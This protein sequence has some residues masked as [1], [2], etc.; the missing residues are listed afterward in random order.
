MALISSGHI[1]EETILAV[2]QGK[3]FELPEYR[4]RRAIMRQDYRFFH[5]GSGFVANIFYAQSQWER[6]SLLLTPEI[7][8]Y[9]TSQRRVS[10]DNGQLGFV[11]LPRLNLEME[12][13]GFVR[14]D[15]AD[16]VS[17]LVK[18]GL[19]EADSSVVDAVRGGDCFKTTASGWAHMRLLSARLEYITS[20]LPT[21]P[22][23]DE[24][25]RANVFDA[26]QTEML[27]GFNSLNRQIIMGEQFLR[28]LR[29]LDQEQRRHP[30]Y[31]QLRPFGTT[32]VIEKV[33]SAIAHAK[34]VSVPLQPDLLDT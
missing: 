15:V 32:Y 27:T 30:G 26:M 2:A 21:T 5:D 16:S 23:D 11:A 4:I 3:V 29:F 7:L 33:A 8:F 12:M 22:M 1:P 31:R 34:R 19:V 14:R 20:V 18:H 25:L 9:L 28:Y 6:P 10:G 13:L 17:Y 24:A